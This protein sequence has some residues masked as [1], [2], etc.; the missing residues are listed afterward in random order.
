MGAMVTDAK[1]LLDHL[2]HPLGGPD[3]SSKAEGFG[4]LCQ[5]CWQLCTLLLTQSRLS[6]WW[7]LMPQGFHSLCLCFFEPL[8]HRA[9][10]H[11]EC[12]SD[13]FLFPSL[14]VSVPRHAS[15]VLRANFVEMSIS[16]SYLLPSAFLFCSLHFSAQVNRT[17][18]RR[19]A[20][21]ESS[22]CTQSLLYR[23]SAP[24]R[25]LA[26]WFDESGAQS[27]APPLL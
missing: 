22:L 12:G 6:S 27:R 16:C 13:V 25:V 2:S 15:V 10:A 5:Q 24:L 9:L 7:W 8:T 18:S 1:L 14:R 23:S 26:S 19:G 11:P 21:L 4:S 17:A 20:S 3:L